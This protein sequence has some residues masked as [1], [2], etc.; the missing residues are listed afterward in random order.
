MFATRRF[1]VCISEFCQGG[2]WNPGSDVDLWI[3]DGHWRTVDLY[4]WTPVIGMFVLLLL[5]YSYLLLLCCYLFFV[6]RCYLCFWKSFN[7][8]KC[9]YIPYIQLTPVRLS[10]CTSSKVFTLQ[11]RLVHMEHLFLALA[12]DETIACHLCVSWCDHPNMN[13]FK[14]GQFLFCSQCYISLG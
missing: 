11:H 7:W 10:S 13:R 9:R 5:V 4:V 3:D 2:P 8:S 12:R 1:Q 14:P 6:V